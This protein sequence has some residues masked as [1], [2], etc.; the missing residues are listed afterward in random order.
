[1]GKSAIK[2]WF[3]AHRFFFKKSSD[4]KGTDYKGTEIDL[5]IDCSI[6]ASC[7]NELN[8]PGGDDDQGWVNLWEH[9]SLEDPPLF[10]KH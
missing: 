6:Y 7:V 5:E 2:M 9:L 10:L 4:Y 8:G 3:S 1:M